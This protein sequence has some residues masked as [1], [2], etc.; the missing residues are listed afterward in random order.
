MVRKILI[1]AFQMLSA[2]ALEWSDVFL[3]KTITGPLDEATTEDLTCQATGSLSEPFTSQAPQFCLAVSGTQKN[4]C[5][6]PTHDVYIKDYV[7]GLWPEEC[8]Q[9][10]YDNLNVL[11]CLACS[12]DQPKYTDQANKIVR[13]CRSV[14][15]GI[16]GQSDLTA[17]STKFDECGAWQEFDTIITLKDIDLGWKGGY[18]I[19][20]DDPVLIYPGSEFNNA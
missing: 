13:V 18:E 3:S 17:H 14:I 15:E 10:S 20:Q 6:T 8:A 12:P 7:L 4:R 1:G 16:Y 9:K 2:S 19:N 5:C 11:A